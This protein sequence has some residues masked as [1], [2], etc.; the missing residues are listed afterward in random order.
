MTEPTI[1]EEPITD[2][3]VPTTDV[4]GTPVEPIAEPEVPLGDAPKTGDS[5]NAVPF[6]ALALAAGAGLVIVR[7][8]FN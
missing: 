2:P 6:A 7:R 8:K 3:D 5:S 1:P 4:P